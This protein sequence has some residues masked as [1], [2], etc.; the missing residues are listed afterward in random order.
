MARKSEQVRRI[1]AMEGCLD[2][3]NE[4]VKAFE[5]ALEGL[6]AVQEDIDILELYY[7]SKQWIKDYEADEAGKLPEGL[8]R[9]VLSEDGIYDL[10]E[11]NHAAYRGML[12]AVKEYMGE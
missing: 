7:S 1:E 6:K 3:A 4:A 9:G 2:A 5:E 11:A 12:D 10:L 8:K